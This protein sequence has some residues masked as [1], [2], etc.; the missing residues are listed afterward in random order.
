MKRDVAGR[1]SWCNTV[2]PNEFKGRKHLLICE[3]IDQIR[4]ISEKDMMRTLVSSGYQK[5]MIHLL[6]FTLLDRQ[7]ECVDNLDLATILCSQE[8]A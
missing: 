7:F 2:P 3:L 6:S 4:R 5:S 8:R 1:W